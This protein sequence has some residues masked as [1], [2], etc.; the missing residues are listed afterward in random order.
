MDQGNCLEQLGVTICPENVVRGR[1]RRWNMGSDDSDRVPSSAVLV[2]EVGSLKAHGSSLREKAM[3]RM[4]GGD[5]MGRSGQGFGD[6]F[7]KNLTCLRRQVPGDA[8]AIGQP[9]EQQFVRR[10][11][12]DGVLD[13]AGRA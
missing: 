10:G 9:A 6:F 3:R 11:R 8:T 12:A 2:A 1:R 7:E 5:G 13:Q 4:L